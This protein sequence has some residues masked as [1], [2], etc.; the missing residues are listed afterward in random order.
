[1]SDRGDGA[2]DIGV[3][4]SPVTHCDTHAAFSTPGA[5]AKEGFARLQN[6]RYHRVGATVVRIYLVCGMTKNPNPG[7]ARPKDHWTESIQTGAHIMTDSTW[8]ELVASIRA[9]WVQCAK[10]LH[11]CA[12]GLDDGLLI[13]L[14]PHNA[15]S[16]AISRA[17]MCAGAKGYA[18]NPMQV[19]VILTKH[20][21]RHA[22]NSDGY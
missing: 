18:G 9:W 2:L 17:R 15:T 13:L 4:G 6:A 12:G 1:V 21:I 19:V 11:R 22:L 16:D 7:M 5:A 14:A 8:D 10:G 3:I 20:E